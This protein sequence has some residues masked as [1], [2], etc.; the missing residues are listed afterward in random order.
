MESRI[1]LPT[2]NIYKFYALFG[3]FLLITS[4]FG[5][6]YSNSS[7]NEKIHSLVKE[8]TEVSIQ[9]VNEDQK[10]LVEIIEKRI[11]NQVSN[12][13]FYTL[14]LGF[15][16]GVAILLMFYGFKKWH[17]DIQPKQD[18]YLDLQLEKLRAEVKKIDD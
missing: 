8:Y 12:K 6:L 17:Q 7:T 11:G 15:I 9:A 5:T 3:L 2:D 4:I 1:P 16:A 18:E 10:A 14:S 13:K